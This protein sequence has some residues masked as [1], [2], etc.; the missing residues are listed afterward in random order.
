MTKIFI[1]TQI[2]LNLYNTKSPVKK[3]LDDIDKI[4]PNIVFPEQVLDE[5]VRNRDKK[6]RELQRSIAD[7]HNIC[8]F[9]LFRD[10]SDFIECEEY[11][12]KIQDLS[13]KMQKKCDELLKSPE[14]DELFNYFTKLYEDK[15]VLS[16]KRTPEIIKKAH[17]RKCIGNPPI[18]EK[19]TTIGDEINWESLLDKVK[20][21]LIIISDDHTYRH[22]FNFLAAEF[23]KISNKK[24]LGIYDKIS[25]ALPL[26]NK[27]PSSELETFEKE[28]EEK[29]ADK[30]FQQIITFHH[31]KGPS[32]EW[33]LSYSDAYIKNLS[34]E[35]EFS[36]FS[37]S[38]KKKIIEKY[39]D[40]KKR[41]G[42]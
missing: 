5:F 12:K 1:D 25:L 30:L 2:F 29:E 31:L 9:G 3:L 39:F 34:N 8:S 41:D 42:D 22:D 11:L 26:M 33:T 38:T 13:K 14:K 24:L 7:T 19:K 35:F 23:Q 37:P 16:I 28:L 27:K 32:P 15:M 17:Q 40:E 6:I 21:D 10:S 18:S 36:P 4:R 20:D